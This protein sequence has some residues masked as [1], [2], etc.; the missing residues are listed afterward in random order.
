MFISTS[1]ISSFTMVLLATSVNCSPTTLISSREDSSLL[2]FTLFSP[3]LPGQ[4][5][6]G[7][8]LGGHGDRHVAPIQVGNCFNETFAATRIDNNQHVLPGRC[9]LNV[10][11]STGCPGL[12]RA[13]YN[14]ERNCHFVQGAAGTV[15]ELRSWKVTCP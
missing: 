12:P 9:S 6:C 15:V 8:H 7:P 11:D 2:D 3:A 4:D 10:Y 14:D 1:I 13:V 5:K